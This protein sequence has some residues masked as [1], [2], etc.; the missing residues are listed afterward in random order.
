MEHK[1]R[2]F[3][4]K[5]QRVSNLGAYVEKQAEETHDNLQGRVRELEKQLCDIRQK[6]GLLQEKLSKVLAETT[7]EKLQQQSKLLGENHK[8]TTLLADQQRE[9]G[10]V[11]EEMASLHDTTKLNIVVYKQKEESFQREEHEFLETNTSN[12]DKL[13]IVHNRMKELESQIKTY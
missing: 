4:D 8:L 10:E 13:H 9:K 6:H 7:K 3:G 11:L 2:E 1:L 12:Q 5:E